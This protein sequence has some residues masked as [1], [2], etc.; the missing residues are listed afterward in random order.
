MAN[1]LDQSDVSAS[2][3]TDNFGQTSLTRVAQGFTPSVSA[4]VGRIILRLRRVG[5]V[6]DNVFVQICSDTAGAPG[7]VIGTSADV[8]GST[9]N[10]TDTQVTFDFSPTT[11]AITASTLYWI[12]VARDGALDDTNYYRIRGVVPTS[13][14]AGGENSVETG[15]NWFSGNDTDE[16]FEEYY[17][18]TT[19]VIPGSPARNINLLGVG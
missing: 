2:N 11:S 9:I 7:A 15:G 16:Y 5:T 19:I 10:T 17:D 18:D 1:V 12:V 3:T 6:T 8:V 4:G 14:Y 13:S